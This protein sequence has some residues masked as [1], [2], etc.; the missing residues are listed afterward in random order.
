MA[1]KD[2]SL[3]Y[4]DP[5]SNIIEN[6]ITHSSA[7]GRNLRVAWCSRS[8]SE[9]PIVTVSASST[10]LRQIVLWDKRNWNE[11]ISVKMI[12]NGS[13]QLF[14]FY[15]EGLN[16]VYLA[17]K[18]DTMIRAY[19]ISSLN[20]NNNT[21]TKE[22]DGSNDNNDDFSYS[23]EKCM[24][25]Q[26]SSRDPI[27]GLCILPKRVVDI[28]QVE[29]TRMLKLSGDN[30]TPISFHVP[31]ADYLKS[32]FHDDIYLP[33]PSNT[34]STAAISDWKDVNAVKNNDSRFLPVKESMKPK[35]MMNASEKPVSPLPSESNSKITTYKADIEA[36]E[37]ET[38]VNEEKFNRLQALAAQNAQYHRNASGPV[39]IGGVVVTNPQLKESGNSGTKKN[40]HHKTDDDSDEEFDWS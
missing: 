38:K 21:H 19:E 30:I 36:K 26:T 28:S 37:K 6:T 5:R 4:I 34:N 23:F 40:N 2:R 39:K 33:I 15:D 12:D 32:Y 13:G 31:R 14:P 3:R 27:A 16:I 17:G 18:G 10:G 1:S 20:N 7:L 29:V 35:N 25:Y 11:P 8:M 22:G 24:D 9:D